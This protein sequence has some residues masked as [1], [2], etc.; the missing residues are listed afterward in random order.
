MRRR[1]FIILLFV[2]LACSARSE[3]EMLESAVLQIR[4]LSGL[5][6][7]M[8]L[9]WKHDMVHD[10]PLSC[11]VKVKY[12]ITSGFGSRIHPITRKRSFHSGIDLAVDLATPVYATASGT[13]V[14]ASVKGGYGRCIIVRHK[15]G[16]STLYGHLIAYYVRAGSKVEQGTPIGFV[17]STGRSTGNH[18]HYEIR[19]NNKPIKPEWYDNKR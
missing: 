16:F 14:Y 15:Y 17:G 18:L 4:S 10:I 13:V 8:D 3:K 6:G 7:V 11:P 2:T 9:L 19:K 12:R 5:H 1:T